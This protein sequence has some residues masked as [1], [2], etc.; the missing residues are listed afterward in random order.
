MKNSKREQ[1]EFD[2]KTAENVTDFY[3]PKIH[4]KIAKSLNMQF[5]A[6][7]FDY[8]VDQLLVPFDFF[9]LHF[10]DN[11]FVSLIYYLYNPFYSFRRFLLMQACNTV[12]NSDAKY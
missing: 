6:Q 10:S 12:L 7:I 11:F 5:F 9:G 3:G 2:T 4:Q 8:S 1:C